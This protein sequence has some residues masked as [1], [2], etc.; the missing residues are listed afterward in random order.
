MRMN[1]FYGNRKLKETS[2]PFPILEKLFICF[3]LTNISLSLKY[4]MKTSFEKAPPRAEGRG[5][6]KRF[7]LSFVEVFFFLVLNDNFQD[8]Y[9]A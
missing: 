4:Q 2:N 6:W 1:I 3:T 8:Y 5:K 9:L 7:D